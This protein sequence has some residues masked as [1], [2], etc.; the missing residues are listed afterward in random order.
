M[1]CGHFGRL[2]STSKVVSPFALATS[3]YGWSANL[4]RIMKAQALRGDLMTFY[5]VNR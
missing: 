2:L 3:E 1:D 5:M 4:E